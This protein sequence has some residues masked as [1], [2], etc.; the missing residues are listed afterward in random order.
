MA[1]SA[2]ATTGCV[3]SMMGRSAQVRKLLWRQKLRKLG[4]YLIAR[5]MLGTQHT[6]TAET[7]LCMCPW[8][9]TLNGIGGTSKV[10]TRLKDTSQR[11]CLYHKM[12]LCP[13]RAS[14]AA[15]AKTGAALCWRLCKLCF[16]S[17]TGHD[18]ACVFHI[19]LLHLNSLPND[20]IWY[21]P[22]L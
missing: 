2:S 8:S 19:T 22:R 9:V 5:N 10:F 3:R 12:G 20:G 18:I 17:N 4:V 13:E 14:F 1:R 16:E 21:L 6:D 11:H 15:G 7:R